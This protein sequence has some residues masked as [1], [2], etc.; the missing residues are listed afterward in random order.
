M[1]WGAQRDGCALASPGERQWQIFLE[2]HFAFERV[3]PGAID[4]PE[5]AHADHAAYFE[6]VQDAP[7]RERP[8]C[9]KLKRPLSRDKQRRLL[10]AQPRSVPIATPGNGPGALPDFAVKNG[11]VRGSNTKGPVM[12]VMSA[13]QVIARNALGSLLLVAL[14]GA[15]VAAL[16]RAGDAGVVDTALALRGVPF[17]TGGTTPQQGFDC[18][19]FVR[20]VF[21]RSS[22][23]ELP[24]TARGMAGVGEPVSRSDLSAGDLVF[25]NT[26]GHRYSHVGI[27]VSE[28]RF[29][30]SPSPGKAVS[31]V[32][33][34]EKYW[35]QR[36]TGARRVLDEMLSA[37]A[38]R[39][40]RP[41]R[42]SPRSQ[43]PPQTIARD[44][45]RIA[46]NGAQR[47]DGATRHAEV[48]QR[49]QMRT[50]RRGTPVPS[51][52][53]NEADRDYASAQP[54]VIYIAPSRRGGYVY[55][56]AAKEVR[57]ANQRWSAQ[58]RHDED[59]D[60]DDD[61]ADD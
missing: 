36:F 17:R 13:T 31:V 6:L 23:F 3:I 2:R 14:P 57:Y 59:E 48:N 1:G 43:P 58:E 37:Q 60:H 12:S 38:P 22:G 42:D 11:C 40:A 53:S 55:H 34:N 16:G 54:L 29:V 35:A 45:E 10:R 21:Q 5:T 32:D 15:S 4:D 33:M 52:I 61:E 25:F 41:H 44:Q 18:S 27:Y 26:Q 51:H 50:Q 8:A 56:V 46:R 7:D 30:H 20:Y 39:N 28:G 24:R 49:S 9:D 47:N 19:G